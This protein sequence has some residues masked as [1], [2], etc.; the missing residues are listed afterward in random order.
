[1]ENTNALNN[2]K[3]GVQYDTT[4]DKIQFVPSFSVQYIYDVDLSKAI[5]NNL[6]K[7][8]PKMATSVAIV[9]VKDVSKAIREGR[10]PIN[11][12]AQFALNKEMF[13]TSINPKVAALI[14][15][16][17]EYNLTETAREKL[18]PFLTDSD[19]V[20]I[21]QVK[22]SK[23]IRCRI[24]GIKL[25]PYLTLSSTLE[26]PQ[27]NVFDIMEVKPYTKQNFVLAVRTQKK[28]EKKKRQQK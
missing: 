25:N 13:K 27:G 16:E 19:S 4:L 11:I 9:P 15:A 26:I 21:R 12:Y 7:R 1:M 5:L 22:L 28:P 17:E 6:T 14:N 3:E 8:F 10:C 24:V 2:R 20:E 18:K 23:K